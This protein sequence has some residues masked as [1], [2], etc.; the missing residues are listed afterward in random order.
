MKNIL[1]LFSLLTLQSFGH[2]SNIKAAYAIGIFD[3]NGNGENIQ[4]VKKTKANYNNT[5]YTKIFA[6]G[7]NIKLKPSVSIGNSIGHFEK[8]KP[9]Y[10]ARKIKIGEVLI[11]KHYNVKKGLIK[12]YSNKKLF[13]SKVFVK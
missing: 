6:V 8:S 9:I 3:V 1:L 4:H 7:T 12:V 10:N 11:Y 13:D 5:C 2:A